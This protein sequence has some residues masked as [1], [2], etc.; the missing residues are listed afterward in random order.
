[1]V[2]KQILPLI[3]NGNVDIVLVCTM[4]SYITIHNVVSQATTENRI[5]QE[6]LTVAINYCII[7]SDVLEADAKTN[8][9]ILTNNLCCILNPKFTTLQSTAVLFLFIPNIG[10]LHTI[11]CTSYPHFANP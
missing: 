9:K 3:K 5:T 10:K 4:M 2:G 8:L 1:M 7:V 11:F 6:K